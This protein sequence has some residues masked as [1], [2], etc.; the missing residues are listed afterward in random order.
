MLTPPLTP[1]DIACTTATHDYLFIL[2]GSPQKQKEKEKGKKKQGEKQK[3][4][5]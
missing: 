1:S 5:S 4:H 3:N 2:L